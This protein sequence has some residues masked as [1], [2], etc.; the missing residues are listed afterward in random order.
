MLAKRLDEALNNAR[1]QIQRP[2]NQLAVST[3]PATNQPVQVAYQPHFQG[4]PFHPPPQHQ[5]TF[6]HTYCPT[7]ATHA[8]VNVTA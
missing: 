7:Y 6:N 5:P 4:P 3:Q 2:P 1:Q 8:R